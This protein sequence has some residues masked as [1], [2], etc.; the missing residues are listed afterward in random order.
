MKPPSSYVRLNTLNI[1][2]RFC[3][4]CPHSAEALE[5]GGGDESFAGHRYA[6]PASGTQS[7]PSK[8]LGPPFPPH[9]FF[10]SRVVSLL[11]R[12]S[13]NLHSRG[14]PSLLHI[15]LF[16]GAHAICHLYI[17]SLPIEKG[18][19]CSWRFW[20]EGWWADWR[21]AELVLGQQHG[22]IWIYGGEENNTCPPCSLDSTSEIG[23]VFRISVDNWGRCRWEK[24]STRR[25]GLT[26]QEAEKPW[27]SLLAKPNSVW[28]GV[29]ASYL[30]VFFSFYLEST[31]LALVFVLPLWL[32][33]HVKVFGLCPYYK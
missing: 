2:E 33:W 17:A 30:C 27:K 12:Q 11:N 8:P 7:T 14:I 18:G 26:I 22:R 3:C 10:S 21:V 1:A 15:L 19:E 5:D 23:E 9:L 24:L 25:L 29:T 31:A 32:W 13:L 16:W 20:F 6:S 4:V 28:N